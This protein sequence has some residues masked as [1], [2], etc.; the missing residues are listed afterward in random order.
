MNSELC[1]S[2]EKEKLLLIEI[3]EE[4]IEYIYSVRNLSSN[5]V[6][7]YKNDLLH[8]LEFMQKNK[9][10][11]QIF[12]N[13]ITLQDLKSSIGA[14]SRARFAATSINRYIAALRSFFGYCKRFGHISLN[15]AAEL[16]TVKTPSRIPAFLSEKEMAKMCYQPENNTLLWKSRDKALFTMLYSSG[17][18]I[19]EIQQLKVKD[20][21]QDFSSAI[22]RGKGKKDRRVFFSEEA[23]ASLKEYLL[24]RNK[25]ISDTQQVEEIFVSQRGFPL[26]IRGIRYIVSRYSSFEGTNKPISPHG[27]RH[28][29]ATSMVARGADV[30]VVQELLG[31]A[32]IST[33]QRYTHITT[34]QL[35]DI[36]NNAHPHGG[37]K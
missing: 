1:T 37:K 35:I 28:S 15:P 7:A 26:T 18:R 10:K 13:Q 6:L 12:L 33:T 11:E 17:C 34:A 21:Q 19:S 14:F 32:S 9:Q 24:E 16:K 4:F 30:R 20:L 5:S 31:H 27:F 3:I 36:Y 25:R 2:S 23:V 8:F 29:F 22:V